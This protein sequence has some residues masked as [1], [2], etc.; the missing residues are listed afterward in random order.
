MKI[1]HCALEDSDPQAADGSLA[2]ADFAP[3][4]HVYTPVLR[5][6]SKSGFPRAEG[7]GCDSPASAYSSRDTTELSN[8]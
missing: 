7:L 8:R 6:S 5:L 2:W 1:A 3:N 4:L